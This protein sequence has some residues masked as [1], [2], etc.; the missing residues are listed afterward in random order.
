MRAI[1]ELEQQ[2]RGWIRRHSYSFFSSLGTLLQHKAGTLMTVTVLAIAIL[3]PLGLYVTLIN[4]DRLDIKQEDWNAVMALVSSNADAQDVQQLVEKTKQRAD[5]DR[6]TLVSPEQGM[7]EFSQSSGFGAS[8]G[9]LT[10]NPLPWVMNVVPAETAKGDPVTLQ[11]RI[12]SLMA[13]LSEDPLV[14]SVQFDYKWLQ[15]LGRFLEL[16]RAAVVVLT[17]LFGFAVVVLVA[18]TIRLD[19]AARAEEIEILALVGA[20]HSFIRQPFLYSG[21]WYGLMGGV[22]SLILLW[23]AQLYM[24]G[25]MARLLDAYGQSFGMVSLSNLQVV[26][27]LGASALLG[28]LGAFT[29]VQRY[30]R[31]LVVGGSLGRR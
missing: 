31:L 19:V 11:L 7:A 10:Q 26:V 28:W 24:A 16:G 17:V 22:C 2:I 20:S 12:Q 27:L 25:P 1:R 8:L 13:S 9:T 30:L 21:L 4:V 6:V 29:S 5:V 14:E 23:L 3:L 15:R 18:N